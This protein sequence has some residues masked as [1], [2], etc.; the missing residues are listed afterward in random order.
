L[1][2]YD[3]E[4]CFAKQGGG[5]TCRPFSLAATGLPSRAPGHRP[6]AT[7][8]RTPLVLRHDLNINVDYPISHQL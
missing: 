4:Y 6:P 7:F 1:R 2:F 5:E 8:R 3:D